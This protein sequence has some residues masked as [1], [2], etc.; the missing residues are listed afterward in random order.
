[1]E[2][3]KR[4]HGEINHVQRGKEHRHGDKISL[5]ASVLDQ[6]FSMHKLF[7]A[8]VWPNA[9]TC[10][11]ITSINDLKEQFQFFVVLGSLMMRWS[12][13][14]HI[15]N[16]QCLQSVTD[17]SPKQTENVGQKRPWEHIIMDLSDS[18][19]ALLQ[20]FFHPPFGDLGTYLNSSLKG[21]RTRSGIVAGLP[22][23]KAPG[24]MFEHQGTLGSPGSCPVFQYHTTEY[25]LQ[26]HYQ[27][28]F[29]KQI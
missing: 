9:L 15:G 19:T 28:G 22:S 18:L 20:V 5:T 8:D 23:C 21:T 16:I 29:K 10:Y 1:M 6:S 7:Q 25:I 11:K 13:R 14:S 4:M 2:V 26:L 27:T 17:S 12:P 3:T 24:K